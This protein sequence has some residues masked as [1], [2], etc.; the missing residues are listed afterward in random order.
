MI[1]PLTTLALVRSYKSTFS[2]HTQGY[3]DKI[4][5]MPGLVG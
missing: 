1:Y 4:Y 5:I 3:A 2:N